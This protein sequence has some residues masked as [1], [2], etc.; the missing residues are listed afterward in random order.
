MEDFY[1]NDLDIDTIYG[2][3]AVGSGEDIIQRKNIENDIS[4]KFAKLFVG[5]VMEVDNDNQIVNVQHGS[6]KQK[7]PRRIYRD[8]K[9]LGSFGADENDVFWGFK[10]LPKKGSEV[11]CG[12]LLN[13][14]EQPIVLGGIITR[15]KEIAINDVSKENVDKDG[16]YKN[17]DI[18]LWMKEDGTFEL[19][20]STGAKMEIT[21]SGVINIVGLIEV[22]LGNNP[23]KNL[24]NN[25]INCPFIL[26]PH[27]IGNI[28]VK[29]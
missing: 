21:S 16:Y 3:D 17:G 7:T 15:E 5:T 9:I 23:S 24:C 28:Q 14:E 29:C 20:N 4:M 12:F 10:Q 19:K 11:V 25:Y 6:L 13:F 2:N 1:Y 26:A 22:N 18:E 8:C 27:A